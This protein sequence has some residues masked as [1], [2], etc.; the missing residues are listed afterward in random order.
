MRASSTWL[1]AVPVL[2]LA[3]W[4][5]AV[6]QEAGDEEYDARRVWNRI[7]AE[8]EV[9]GVEWGANAFLVDV[10][11]GLEQGRALDIGMGQGRNALHLASQGWEVTGYDISD[12]ALAQARRSAE[13]AGL[14][15]T[16]HQADVAD[17]D[18]GEDRWDLI[19][20]IYMH[21]LIL[22]RAREI[23]DSLKPGGLLVV[24]GFHRD[25]GVKSV[26]GE[27]FGFHTNQLL[28]TFDDLR[29]LYYED[30]SDLADWGRGRLSGPKPIVRFVARKEARE[31]PTEER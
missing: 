30:V 4:S 12:E 9:N 19:A 16:M 28:R 6:L 1:F 13:E 15:L 31:A 25:L 3:A 29:V 22:P 21:E 23:V 27:P 24:E 17:F 11:A 7:F 2:V 8:A 10:A 26:D 18:Y 14:E 5:P 20:A